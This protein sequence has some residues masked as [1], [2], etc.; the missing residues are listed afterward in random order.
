MKDLLASNKKS[1]QKDVSDETMVR[2]LKETPLL[3]S[4]SI[5]IIKAVIPNCKVRYFSKGSIV[6]RPNDPSS[7]M[8]FVYSGHI[9][10]FVGYGSSVD[11]IVKARRAYDYIGEMGMLAN[12]SYANTA[13]AMENLTLIA[14]PKEVFIKLTWDNPEVSHYI[15]KQLILR[16]TGSAR[17][18][19]ST[20]YLDAQGRLAFTIVALTDDVAGNRHEISV[21]QSDIA[22]STGIARQTVAKIL[23]EWRKEGWISTQ[24]GKI[25][26]DDLDALLDIIISSELK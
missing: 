2:F 18:M 9:V 23:G 3:E 16:L 26:V 5:N 14:V 11:I 15:I 22:A 8:Y 6:F 12:E 17:K 1:W 24:R 4:L 7:F 20:M 25:S 19:I 21:T 10:E 13:V